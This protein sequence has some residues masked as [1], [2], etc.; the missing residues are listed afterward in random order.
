MPYRQAGSK[1][2]ATTEHT[3]QASERIPLARER[4]DAN[5]NSSCV[6][7]SRLDRRVR[8]ITKVQE[9]MSYGSQ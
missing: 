8:H 7:Q 5:P 3:W 4:A 9:N 2:S 6:R 1:Q